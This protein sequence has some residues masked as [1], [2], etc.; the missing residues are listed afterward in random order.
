[1]EKA[2]VNKKFISKKTFDV[3]KKNNKDDK[4]KDKKDKKEKKKWIIILYRLI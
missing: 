3:S 4:K 1:M 2:E